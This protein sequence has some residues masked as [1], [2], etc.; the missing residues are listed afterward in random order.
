MDDA[1]GGSRGLKPTVTSSVV[2]AVQRTWGLDVARAGVLGGSTGLNLLV[3]GAD[4]RVVVR[5][6]RSH[7]SAGRVLALQDAREA[8]ASRGVP[9][10]PTVL[11]RRGER[12]AVAGSWVIEAEAFIESDTTMD[13]LPRIERA[14]PL[15]ARLHAALDGIELPEGADELRFGNYLAAA[16]TASKTAAGVQRIRELGAALHP[17]AELTEAVLGKVT[18]APTRTGHLP[19]QGCH[20]DYWDNNVSF[21]GGDV[22]LVADFGFVNR[23]P[24]IDDLALTLYFTLWELDTAHHP[25][26]VAE[27]AALVDAYDRGAQGQ[28]SPDERAD[29]PVALARQALWSIG[30][31]AVELD[32]AAVVA[33]LREHDAALTCALDILENID[34]WR[35]ALQPSPG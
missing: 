20:G 28:L 21:K 6:H 22:V 33:H 13:S 5:V 18:A 24:R 27:L 9:T 15:L 16:D 29:L 10:A 25:D 31:W 14:M 12:H 1:G 7:V 30:V 2:G 17:I 32:D 23:R 34:R 11:G 8:V 35:H 19:G 4:G 26:P 3:D